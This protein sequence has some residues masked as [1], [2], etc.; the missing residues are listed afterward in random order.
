[1]HMIPVSPPAPLAIASLAAAGAALASVIIRISLCML[2]ASATRKALEDLAGG[3]ADADA[4]RAHRL[5]VL[6]AVLAALSVCG[7]SETGE[8]SAQL[9]LPAQDSPRSPELVQNISENSADASQAGTRRLILMWQGNCRF[10]VTH[11]L[12]QEVTGAI[13][14]AI[15]QPQGATQALVKR[16][17]YA[18]ELLSSY[19]EPHR[20]IVGASFASR[21]SADPLASTPRA[22]HSGSADGSGSGW[23]P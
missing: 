2:A 11:S 6:R 17:I 15:V 14:G 18:I 7:H 22:R 19:A 1:M 21:G 16:S 12:S 20:P 8:D 5:A 4:L 3:Q 23:L 10:P 9:A 13:W